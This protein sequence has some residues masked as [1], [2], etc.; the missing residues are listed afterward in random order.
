MRQSCPKSCPSAK[1]P[2]SGFYQRCY[3]A[4]ESFVIEPDD[5]NHLVF[6]LSGE[7]S[8]TSEESSDYIVKGGSF[9]L[10]YNCGHYTIEVKSDIEII[11][12]FF[13]RPGA[14]CDIA[15]LL[16]YA[17]SQEGFHYNFEAMIKFY[18]CLYNRL[19]RVHRNN[20]CI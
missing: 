3:S 5:V 17:K 15:S 18:H 10:C 16:Q 1:E 13:A 20:R 7:L 2:F 4:G 9:F 19:I 12:A 8:V 11:V 6:V 14:A